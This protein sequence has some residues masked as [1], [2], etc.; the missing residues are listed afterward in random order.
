MK[1]WWFAALVAAL[2]QPALAQDEFDP[3]FEAT[4]ATPPATW[5]PFVEALIRGDRVTGLPGGREDLERVRARVR[6]GGIW[7][8][9]AEDRLSFGVALEGAIGTGANKSSLVN[10]DLEEV[11]GLALDQ[12]WLR[13][14]FGA[15]DGAEAL[16]GKAPLPLSLTP[17]VWDDDLRP[18]GASLRFSGSAGEFDRWHFG[19]GGFAPDPLDERGSRLAAAQF[20]WHWREG[21][22][23]SAGALLGYLHFSSLDPLARAGLGRG[24]TLVAGSYRDEF[25]LLDLQ[26]YLRHQLGGKWLEARINRVRNL[27]AE[28][29][30]DATRASLVY[31]DRFDPQQSGWEFGW[32]WQRQQR[33]AVLAAVTGDEW[34]FHTAARGHMPWVGFGFNAT[35]SIRAAAFFETRDGLDERTER[36]LLD[37]EARW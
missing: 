37:L 27:G 21:A 33:N 1:S 3:D 26:L 19:F 31:G 6:A 14:R 4:D 20:G 16:L 35:W 13:W 25:R 29:E 10:N 23:I 30:D 9:P 11:D 24:N 17:L 22:P 36:W 32:S 7:T 2:V 28:G 5:Q 8:L 12:A 15:G 18:V 34:W